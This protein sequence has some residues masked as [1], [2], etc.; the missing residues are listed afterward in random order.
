MQSS[1]PSGRRRRAAR[2]AAFGPRAGAAPAISDGVVKIGVLDDMSGVFADQQGMGDFVAARMAAEDFGGHVLGAPIEVIA[3]RFAEPPRHRPVD[4]PALVRPGEGRRH[5]RPRQ[6][7]RRAGGAG[8]VQAAPEDRRGD[9]RRHHRPDRQAVLALR[10]ALVS[11]T[12]TPPPRDRS[13]R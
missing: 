9:R 2:R 4:R 12:T 3:A 11:T 13:P 7:R 6:F 5:L 1:K 8:I 10:R